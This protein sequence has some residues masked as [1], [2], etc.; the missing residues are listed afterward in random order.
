MQEKTPKKWKMMV[1]SWIC[2]YPL[3]NIISF[4]VIPYLSG[5]PQLL[6]TLISTLILVPLMV[7]LLSRLQRRFRNWLFK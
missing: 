6:R 7:L 2:I 5:L 3:L 4:L 1:L